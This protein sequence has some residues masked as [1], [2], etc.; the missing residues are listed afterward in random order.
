MPRVS[1]RTE[2][3]QSA[4]DPPLSH[5]RAGIEYEGRIVERVLG[6]IHRLRGEGVRKGRAVPEGE[7]G[8]G[9]DGLALGESASEA[10]LEDFGG[11]PNRFLLLCGEPE[12]RHLVCMH[13]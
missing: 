11:L 5:R 3:V 7:F 8:E 6:E 9:S 12:G 13:A 1:I 2:E 4:D 10:F